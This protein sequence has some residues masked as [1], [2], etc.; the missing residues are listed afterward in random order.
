MFTGIIE[1][2]GNIL[3]V[4]PEK[5]NLHF[6][7]ASSISNQLKVDQSLAHDGVCLTVTT[8]NDHSH[9]VTAVEETLQKTNLKS[10][11]EGTT[12]NLERCL[13][14]NGRFDGH[15][16]QGHVDTIA[17]LIKKEDQNGSVKLYFEYD[18]AAGITVSK[19]SICING[20][21]LTVVDS[22]ENT[23]SVVII[24]YT[25]ENTN[26]GKLAIGNA[27]NIEFDILGKYIQKLMN[28]SI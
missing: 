3:S 9:R 26:L 13:Q 6:T 21:S 20:I 10:W 27:V 22:G 5:G 12:V 2:M 19:G 24:P 18:S 28:K 16:V 7:V 11:I 1:T 23:F 15:I 25:F 14:A 4:E 8:V 17:S